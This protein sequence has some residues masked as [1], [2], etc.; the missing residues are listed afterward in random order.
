MGREREG[1]GRGPGGAR[2]RPP[3]VAARSAVAAGV[4]CGARARVSACAPGAAGVAR[5]AGPG[6]PLSACRPPPPPGARRGARAHS[7]PT[8]P[9]TPDVHTHT[10]REA[11]RRSGR[12]RVR[13]AARWG[14]GGGA[15]GGET[16][17]RGGR[18]GRGGEAAPGRPAGRRPPGWGWCS[19]LPRHPRRGASGA[20]FLSAG[21]KM[22]DCLA[23]PLCYVIPP[24]VHPKP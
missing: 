23:A 8:V 24:V 2:P 7:R 12:A 13:A 1:W 16:A 17:R 15:G 20:L 19:A 10:R 4:G 21:R 5:R 9:H 11:S 18:G 6:R 22:S 14:R 3:R